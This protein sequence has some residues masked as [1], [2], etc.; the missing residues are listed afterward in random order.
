MGELLGRCIEPW[1]RWTRRI[2]KWVRSAAGPSGIQVGPDRPL[3]P[4][5]YKQGHDRPLDPAE[6][7]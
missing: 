5:E 4:A 3:D 2:T 1:D 6:Y 7:K